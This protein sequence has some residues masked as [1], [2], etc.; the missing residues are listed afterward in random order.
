MKAERQ[1]STIINI[2]LH[3][4]MAL[5][6][7]I[8]VTSIHFSENF[9]TAHLKIIN[10]L[11][12]VGSYELQHRAFTSTPSQMK[13]DQLR[14]GRQRFDSRQGQEFFSS[15]PC[16]NRLLSNGCRGSFT[17]AWAARAWNFTYTPDHFMSY[18]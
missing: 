7:Q 4:Q 1:A 12:Y 3:S 16:P 14:A 17:G 10:N 2:Q 13:S 11:Q 18:L 9:W 5:P 6:L 8:L 15:L